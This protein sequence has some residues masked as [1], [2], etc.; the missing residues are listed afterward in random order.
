MNESGSEALEIQYLENSMDELYNQL[1]LNMEHI[2][3]KLFMIWMNLSE[4]ERR[5][6]RIE[7]NIERLSKTNP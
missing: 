1:A 6:E 3:Q 4:M 7:R 2:V 5:I